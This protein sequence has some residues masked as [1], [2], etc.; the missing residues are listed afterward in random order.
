MGPKLFRLLA[1]YLKPVLPGVA[2]E[3]E[4]FLQIPPLCWD[5]IAKPMRNHVIAEFKPLMQRVEMA[6]I[7]AVVEDSK[8]QSSASE[9]A[10]GPLADDPISPTITIEDF[11]KVDLRIARI[12]KAEAVAGADKLVRLEPVSY[13]HLDPGRDKGPHSP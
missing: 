10:V 11:A 6:Q 3:V 8:E 9:E 5:D 12:V 7:A 2:A 13:T 4:Q 1:L